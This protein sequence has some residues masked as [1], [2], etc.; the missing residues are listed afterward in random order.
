ML[1]IGSS[2]RSRFPVTVA[3]PGAFQYFG[4]LWDLRIVLCLPDEMPK[5]SGL[6]VW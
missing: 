1:I 4:Q 3:L 6:S 5:G 2:D